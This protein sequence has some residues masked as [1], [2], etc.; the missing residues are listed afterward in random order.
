MVVTSTGKV[1]T[2]DN[3][4]EHLLS[5]CAAMQMEPEAEGILA[6]MERQVI[7][8]TLERTGGDKPEAARILGIGL[9]TLYRKIERWDL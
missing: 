6:A 7:A 3:L 5:K 1:I 9:R 2:V 4:P 8:E